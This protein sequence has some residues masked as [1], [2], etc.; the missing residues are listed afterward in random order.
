MYCEY[1]IFTVTSFPLGCRAVIRPTDHVFVRPVYARVILELLV[2]GC[3]LNQVSNVICVHVT[4]FRIV[5]YLDNITMDD[6]LVKENVNDELIVSTFN[7]KAT[8]LNVNVFMQDKIVDVNTTS[9]ANKVVLTVH[10]VK[11]IVP[12]SRSA[13]VSSINPSS[14]AQLHHCFN[15]I[16]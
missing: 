1:V 8:P 2:W 9:H 14:I 6:T 13:K 4:R 7:I 16:F 3:S 12:F 11:A 5:I 10:L 15:S